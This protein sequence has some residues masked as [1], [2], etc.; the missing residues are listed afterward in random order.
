V[1]HLLSA[2]SLVAEVVEKMTILKRLSPSPIEAKS[3]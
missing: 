3:R 1:I 2:F